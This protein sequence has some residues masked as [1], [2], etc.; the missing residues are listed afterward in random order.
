MTGALGVL[1]ALLKMHLHEKSVSRFCRGFRVSQQAG[2][3]LHKMESGK[4]HMKRSLVRHFILMVCGVVVPSSFCWVV[5]QTAAGQ[6]GSAKA[7]GIIRIGVASPTVQ[8]GPAPAVD[9]ASEGVRG[10]LMKYLAGPSF[11]IVPLTAQLP[12]QIEAEGRQKECDFV[13]DSALSAKRNGGS[14]LGFLRGVSQM[15]NVIPMLGA[16]H[17][18]VGTI[19][20]A[21]AGTVLS[22]VAGAASMVKAKSEVSFEYRLIAGGNS[23]PVLSDVVKT[24]ATQD[25]E[26]V[27][28]ALVEKAAGA[29]I[30][31]ILS[32]K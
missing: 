29:V 5:A 25:G 10:V 30:N 13:I 11:E 12:V 3:I 14:G 9:G 8:M 16:A 28:S 7:P 6:N 15:S 23:T 24:K 27:I 20:G 22:G 26:D 21:A 31:A 4:D 19:A 2:T 1:S 17:G 18:A 32:K